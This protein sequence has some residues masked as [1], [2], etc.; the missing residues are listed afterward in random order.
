MWWGSLRP[1]FFWSS[2]SRIIVD[3][4]P[5]VY[6]AG[7][8]AQHT[9]YIFDLLYHNGEKARVE[10]IGDPRQQVKAWAKDRVAI[11]DRDSIV[12]PHDWEEARFAVDAQMN[13]IYKNC[14]VGVEPPPTM[15]VILSGKGNYR[16]AVATIVGYKANRKDTVR[17]V[18]YEE[19]RKYMQEGWSAYVVDGREADDEVSIRMRRSTEKT[20][21]ATIDKDLDQIPGLHY[22]YKDHVLYAIDAEDARDLFYAQVLAGDAGDNIPGAKGLGMTKALVLVQGWVADY[23]ERRPGAGTISLEMYLWELVV[24]EYWE[25][26]VD[27]DLGDR[28]PEEVALEVARLVKLQ[29]YPRQLWNPPGIA[30]EL[31]EGNIDD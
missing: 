7:F 11:L 4:D 16:H 6:R 17:P 23:T 14:S 13:G 8:A 18:W 27:E 24:N 30:D 15:E 29:E 5:I 19:I 20:I 2:M 3:G 9:V 10:I 12:I 1:P 31:T 26:G 22:N 21:L 25:R 28:Q